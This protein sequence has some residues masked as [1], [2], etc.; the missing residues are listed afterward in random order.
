MTAPLTIGALPAWLTD[1]A[2]E[3]EE[4]AALGISADVSQAP[5][6]QAARDAQ[7]SQLLRALGR[8]EAEIA[9]REAALEVE[10]RQ[11]KLI[12][13]TQL[14]RLQR[15]ASFLTGAVE[16]L[17]LVSD[18]GPKKKSRTVGFGTYGTRAKPFSVE[19][20]DEAT[21][22]QW[23]SQQLPGAVSTSVTL[24]VDEVMRLT[25]AG[26]GSIVAPE[27]LAWKLAKS[28]VKA[29]AESTGEHDIPG[30]TVTLPQDK[31]FAKALAPKDATR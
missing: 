24:S 26:F 9:E 13:Q 17:A 23:A 7:A 21:T 3:R 1:D 25:D 20:V 10:L 31:P 5:E 18:F 12:Y 16:A 14:E 8:V 4:L 27:R 2:E 19:I 22:L 30:V 29:H 28:V 6:D 15:R 11:V